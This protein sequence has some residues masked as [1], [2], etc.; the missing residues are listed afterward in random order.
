MNW[1]R[2]VL[3][4]LGAGGATFGA[5]VASMPSGAPV[6]SRDV[7]VPVVVSILA[8]MVGLMQPSVRPGAGS[9]PR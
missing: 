6:T 5:V 9:L 1:T 8:N 2:L 4:A 3:N 7:L